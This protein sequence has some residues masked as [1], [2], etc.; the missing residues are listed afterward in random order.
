MKDEAERN[1]MPRDKRGNEHND[2]SFDWIILGECDSEKKLLIF[3][4]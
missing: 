2:W 3:I 1:L 4:D